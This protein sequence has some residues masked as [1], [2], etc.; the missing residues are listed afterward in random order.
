MF[1]KYSLKVSCPM[2]E[3]LLVLNPPLKK[4]LFNF[5]YLCSF[6]EPHIKIS[7]RNNN[8]KPFRNHYEQFG[9]SILSKRP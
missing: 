6:S 4:E 8:R 1:F 7:V 2:H 5:V 9:T 3:K